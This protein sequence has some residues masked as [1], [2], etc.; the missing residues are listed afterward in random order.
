MIR[1]PPRSTLFPYTTLFRSIRRSAA[2]DSASPGGEGRGEGEG[3]PRR[4]N[5]LANGRWAQLR[6]PHNAAGHCW[7]GETVGLSLQNSSSRFVWRRLVPPHPCPL[8]QGE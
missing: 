5:A 4:T 3:S 8:P 2:R 6:S 1:R 7:L